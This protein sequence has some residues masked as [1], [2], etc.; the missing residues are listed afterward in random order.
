MNNIHSE[1]FTKLSIVP[2]DTVWVGVRLWSPCCWFGSQLRSRILFEEAQEEQTECATSSP[3]STKKEHTCWI[4]SEVRTQSCVKYWKCGLNCKNLAQV[5]RLRAKVQGQRWRF[6]SESGLNAGS[7]VTL[8]LAG[9]H[10]FRK[11][12]SF[13]LSIQ[14][15]QHGAL[16]ENRKSSETM[17]LRTTLSAG[18]QVSPI[19]YYLNYR[20]K[21]TW[22]WFMWTLNQGL[23]PLQVKIHYLITYSEP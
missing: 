1:L 14:P 3:I 12:C 23:Q 8:M 10:S 20:K 22:K 6:C 2:A 11:S 19:I 15:S 18:S 13:G 9:D 21:K 5:E 17:D 16:S 7:P 4:E